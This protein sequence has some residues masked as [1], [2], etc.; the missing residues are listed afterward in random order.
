MRVFECCI[1]LEQDS[2]L[3]KNSCNLLIVYIY[4]VTIYLHTLVT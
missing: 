4:I 2:L 1:G 3:L